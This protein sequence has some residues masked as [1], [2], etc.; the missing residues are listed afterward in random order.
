[1]VNSEESTV[2]NEWD[3]LQVGGILSFPPVAFHVNKTL[4][5]AQL[6]VKWSALW[7]CEKSPYAYWLV[8]SLQSASLSS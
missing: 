5:F 4:G 1:M 2:I 8:H 6:F 7:S 3:F